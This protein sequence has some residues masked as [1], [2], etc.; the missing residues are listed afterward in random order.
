MS[1][2]CKSSIRFPL[3]TQPLYKA[4]AGK[5]AATSEATMRLLDKVATGTRRR[6]LE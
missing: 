4:M 3:L 5:V 1:T 2:T 6:F